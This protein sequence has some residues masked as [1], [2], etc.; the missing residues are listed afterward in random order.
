MK[1]D[2]RWVVAACVVCVVPVSCD[3]PGPEEIHFFDQ[4]VVG[5]NSA[6]RAGQ[7]PAGL[8]RLL[9]LEVAT[10]ANR[11]TAHR[12]GERQARRHHGSRQSPLGRTAHPRRDPQ[13][14][15]RRFTTYPGSAHASSA[16]AAL[17]NLA[18]LPPQPRRRSRLGR[19]LRGPHRD[20]SACSGYSWSYSITAAESCIST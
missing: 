5:Q 3:R 2:A 10:R 8:S 18:D 17:A 12:S 15:A 7:W 14:R 6:T 11:S 16:E 1:G 9:E 19:L 13:A 20:P 4:G